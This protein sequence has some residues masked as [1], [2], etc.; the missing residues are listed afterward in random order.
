MK[1]S[2]YVRATQSEVRDNCRRAIESLKG[3]VVFNESRHAEIQT[4]LKARIDECLATMDRIDKEFA[5]QE[6]EV[7]GK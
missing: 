4:R 7:E 2:T 3:E 6:T 5:N 1:M